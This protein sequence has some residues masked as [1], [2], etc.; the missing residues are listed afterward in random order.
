MESKKEEIFTFSFNLS[1][2]ECE[3]PVLWLQEHVLDSSIS[4]H[5][6]WKRGGD[7]TSHRPTEVG[8]ECLSKTDGII[9]D[10]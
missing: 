5:G 8:L 2:N 10:V 1:H 9:L 7:E 4:L 6:F 3:N